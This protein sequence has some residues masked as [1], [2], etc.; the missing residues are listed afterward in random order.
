M[1]RKLR[2]HD[3]LN[4]QLNPTALIIED[5]S[6]RHR[7]PIGAE[8]HFKVV[9]VSKQFEPLKQIDR[10]RLINTILAEEFS[11][12][13]HALSLHPYTPDQWVKISNNIPKSPSCQSGK[14]H[15]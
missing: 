12:G 13:L 9:V 10:H 1:S 7:V 5:E 2:I 14:H 6:N 11:K 8:S 3:A 4:K 15:E